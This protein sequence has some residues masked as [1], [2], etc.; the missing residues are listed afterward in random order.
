MTI[1]FEKYHGAGNDFIM[2]DTKKNTTVVFSEMLIRQLCDRHTGIGSDGLI[3]I[4]PCRGFDFEM[5]FFN[6]DGSQSFC[7]NGS[8]CGVMFA[9]KAGYFLNSSC[10]FISSGR[11]YQANILDKQ[12]VSLVIGDFHSD[13]IVHKSPNAYFLNTGSPHYIEF[14]DSLET[15][16]NLP[17][18]DMAMKIRYS[19]EYLPIGGTNVNFIFFDSQQKTIYIRTYERGVENET[20]ACGSGITAAALI[21]HFTRPAS[22]PQS[23][24]IIAKGGQLNVSFRFQDGIFENVTLTGPAVKVFSGIWES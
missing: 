19:Q 9:H 11:P 13:E 14:V 4:Q 6:P 16:E 10:N 17:L 8:R 5:I 22:G 21:S 1:Y 15:L 23:Y 20:L 18:T 12:N 24:N 3:L 7:G 2:I